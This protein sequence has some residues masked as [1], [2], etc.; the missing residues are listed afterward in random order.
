LVPGYSGVAFGDSNK[1]LPEPGFVKRLDEQGELDG[2]ASREG[3]AFADRFHLN[4]P[5][6]TSGAINLSILTYHPSI[7]TSVMPV[8][9]INSLSEFRSLVRPAICLRFVSDAHSLNKCINT[10]DQLGPSRRRR[11]LGYVVWPLQSHLSHL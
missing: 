8:E 4:E 6:K 3:D 11:L 9:P 10:I 1:S 7:H 5:Y 2:R